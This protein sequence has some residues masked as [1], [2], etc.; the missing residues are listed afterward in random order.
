MRSVVMDELD[1]RVDLNGM[2]ETGLPWGFLDQA[3]D[4][5]GV[6]PGRHLLVGAGA[7][8]A[9]AVVVD[10]DGDVVHVQPLPGSPTRWHHLLGR[11]VP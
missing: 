6:A 1:L 3:R 10:I 7:A 9:V 5:A 11:R 8:I 4:P 2:D